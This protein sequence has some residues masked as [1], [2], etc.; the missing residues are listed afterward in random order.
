M[1]VATFNIRHGAP[2]D[3]W[4]NH[5]AMASSVAS[6][7]ADVVALQEVD[8]RVVRSWFVDQARAAAR[9]SGAVAWFEPTRRMGPGGR[10][11]N[12][13]VVRGRIRR[14][15]V[16]HLPA[17]GEPRLAMFATVIIEDQEVT[18]V[19]THL[20]N[21]RKGR[22]DEAPEQLGALLAA[23]EHW[24]IPRVVMGDLNLRPER[25][26]PAL[27]AAGLDPVTTGPTHPADDP[28]ARIDWIATAGMVHLGASVPA[29]RTSD[30]RPIVAD[31]G[32]RSAGFPHLGAAPADARMVPDPQSHT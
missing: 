21:R 11:G 15:G 3:G 5:R 17:V 23:L 2:A 8:R 26:L 7:A 10:Y 9:A 29:L 31:L 13:L 16:L 24:P 12:A 1:R 25:V 4:A 32:R 22:P 14:R 19:C 18:V 20:Q 30:H 27:A 6:L 28:R